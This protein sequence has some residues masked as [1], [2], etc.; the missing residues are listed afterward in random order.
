M[1]N[2]ILKESICT[3]DSIDRLSGEA[4]R[5]FYRLLVQAD[6]YGRYDG[7]L[8]VIRSRCYP[9]KLETVREVDI[10]AWLGELERE[11]LVRRYLVEGKPYLFFPKWED[12]QQVRSHRKKYP[13]PCLGTIIDPSDCSGNQMISDDIKSNTPVISDDISG[14]H[15]IAAAPGIQSESESRSE[16]RS[17]SKGG[18]SSAP[19]PALWGAIKQAWNAAAQDKLPQIKTLTRE[20]KRKLKARVLEDPERREVGWWSAY[21]VRIAQNEFCT[22]KNTRG[23]RADFDWAIQNETTVAKVLEGTYDRAPPRPNLGQD[24]GEER[25]M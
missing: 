13:D 12:H 20:R 10:E 15:G 2:R 1:P 17:E 19:T 9:L 11:N 14:N 7:R 8:S 18:V 22:G 25:M 5:L 4:E 6:D 21:F 16:S 23:W 24:W 3:S